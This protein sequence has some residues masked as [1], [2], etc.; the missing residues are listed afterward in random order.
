MLLPLTLAG[1]LIFNR[2][3]HEMLPVAVFVSACGSYLFA[4]FASLYVAFVAMCVISILTFIVAFIKTARGTGETKRTVPLVSPALLVLIAVCVLFCALMSYRKVYFYDDL[5]YWAIYTKNIFTID[6]LPALFENCSVDYKDYTPIIQILQYLVM[7]GRSDFSEAAM[8]QTNIC[9]IY[10]LLLPLLSVATAYGTGADHE[11]GR[12]GIFE[13]SKEDGRTDAEPANKRK[14]EIRIAAV[15]VYVIFPHI[16]TAQFYYRLGVDL[17]L[18]LTF[19]YVLF[20]I[21]EGSVTSYGT[22]SREAFEKSETAQ[23]T[24]PCAV[25][26]EIFRMVC[27]AGGLSFLTLIKS[28][29][30]VLSVMAIIMFAIYEERRARILRQAE[31][32]EKVEK[33]QKGNAGVINKHL[34][35]YRKKAFLLCIKTAILCAFTLGSFLSWQWFL[36]RSWNNGYLSNRVKAGVKGGMLVFPAYTKEVIINYIKHFFAFPLTRAG[37]GVTAFVLVVFIIVVFVLQK[38][39]MPSV[40]PGVS[41]VCVI[42]GLAI[43][44][45]AHLSMYLFIFDE[46]EAHGLMEFDRYITQ[47]LGGAFMLYMCILIRLAAN[48]TEDLNDT[49]NYEHEKS[50]VSPDREI[51]RNTDS[52][53]TGK[54]QSRRVAEIVLYVSLAVFLA[55]LPYKDM[56]EYLIPSN[57]RANYEQN[58]AAISEKVKDEWMRSGIA[59]LDLPHDGTAR[60]TLIA[61]AW[62]ESTQFLEYEAVPQP[63]DCVVN[64]PAIEEGG[65]CG[66]I[67]D[68]ME[69][70]VYVAENAKDAYKGDWNESAQ[71]TDDHE[72]LQPG[73]FYR[74]VKENDTKTLVIAE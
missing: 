7:F 46:W 5:S 49:D 64:I 50:D 43:F 13:T 33:E 73:R 72:P 61:D 52:A 45:I 12:F 19:G 25:L 59:D 32:E 27:L 15:I 20:Y 71:L 30:P 1:C 37:F 53:P 17:F 39:E 42:V 26:D 9:L 62:D 28:S 57:Y 70:Y 11:R 69:A 74:I 31:E 4:L 44:C 38:S 34:G 22:S 54:L 48:P 29:G 47:Y 3:V 40:S 51:T 63:F 65:L 8:F 58:Y 66:F 23:G 60:I 6:K 14:V 56:R 41:F 2:R 36:R 67:E 21:F 55:L 18:A 35:I 10:V 24:V 16:L 68:H